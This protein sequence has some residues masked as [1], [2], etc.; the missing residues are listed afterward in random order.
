MKSLPLLIPL[1]L[2]VLSSSGC[3]EATRDSIVQDESTPQAMQE[4]LTPPVV[5]REDITS[6]IARVEANNIKEVRRRLKSVEPKGPTCLSG[7]HDKPFPDDLELVFKNKDISVFAYPNTYSCEPPVGERI[8]CDVHSDSRYYVRQ[9]EL[10]AI[11]TLLGE[12]E[13]KVVFGGPGAIK[14]HKI[15][16]KKIRSS[17][18]KT[19]Q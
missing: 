19:T 5:H 14:C 11:M 4:A 9:G 10:G 12:G 7:A 18:I 16:K 13:L 17:P 8:L 2:I 1:I 3:G 6:R 15:K